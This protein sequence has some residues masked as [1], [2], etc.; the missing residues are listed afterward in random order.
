MTNLTATLNTTE[1]VSSGLD[2]SHPAPGDHPD[3]L[4]ANAQ[5]GT[6]RSARN[7]LQDVDA[8]GDGRG[9]V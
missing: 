4:I 3:S 2:R 8:D 9:V 5:V 7:L 1:L 6:M